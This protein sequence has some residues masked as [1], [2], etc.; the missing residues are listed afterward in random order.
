MNV[1]EFLAFHTN[2]VLNVPLYC[3]KLSDNIKSSFR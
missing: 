2:S 1:S 3:D